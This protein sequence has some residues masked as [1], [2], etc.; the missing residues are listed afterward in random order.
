MLKFISLDSDEN[1]CLSSSLPEIKDIDEFLN[2]KTSKEIHEF[3]IN[4]LDDS[5]KKEKETE[6]SKTNFLNKILPMIF[7][8]YLAKNNFSFGDNT[9]ETIEKILD[10]SI[11]ANSNKPNSSHVKNFVKLYFII[12]SNIRGRYFLISKF[13]NFL[14]K[15]SNN[16]NFLINIEF[17]FDVI[18]NM[19]SDF[20]LNEK[21]YERKEMIMFYENFSLFI[22]RNKLFE[23]L[24]K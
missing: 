2:K 16:E 13:L 17:K 11:L 8:E 10:V 21:E 1:K 14:N 6:K 9:K 19:L 12:S 18:E 4:K 5:N 22:Y 20:L 7:Y 24:N 15:E 3:I 23:C